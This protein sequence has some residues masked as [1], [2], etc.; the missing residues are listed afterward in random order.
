M[1]DS[2]SLIAKSDWPDHWPELF[3]TLV[4]YLHVKIGMGMF[5][6]LRVL[7]AI[8]GLL[9]ETQISNVGPVILHEMYNIF[10]NNVSTSDFMIVHF[11]ST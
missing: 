4:E 8:V 11:L 2:V 6:S 7:T 10:R 9:D 1:A 3:D 5:G